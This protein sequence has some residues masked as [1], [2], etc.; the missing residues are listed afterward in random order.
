M[1]PQY[2]FEQPPPSSTP[3]SRIDTKLF[4]G[5]YYR[6]ISNGKIRDFFVK[7]FSSYRRR[8]MKT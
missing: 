1:S 7:S 8:P 4:G 6:V 3:R 2:F 5:H